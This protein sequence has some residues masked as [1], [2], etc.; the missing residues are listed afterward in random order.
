MVGRAENGVENRDTAF[1]VHVVPWNPRRVIDTPH[2]VFPLKYFFQPGIFSAQGGPVATVAVKDALRAVIGTEDTAHPLSDMA[3]A[4]ALRARGFAIARRTVAKYRDEL[5]IPPC[6]RRTTG[7]REHR[8]TD[9]QSD[10]IRAHL[11]AVL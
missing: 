4:S 5:G 7:P 2:G 1:E 8:R 9:S 10:R 3:L 11:T 6:H